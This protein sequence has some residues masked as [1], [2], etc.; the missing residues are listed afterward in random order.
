MPILSSEPTQFPAN[1][2]SDSTFADPQ[3]GRWWAMHTRSR[4]EKALA[5]HLFSRGVSYYLPLKQQTWRNNGRRFQSLLP[6]FPG[7]VFVRGSD[8]DRIAALESNLI[9][10]ILDVPD[11][12]RL[13]CDLRRVQCVLDADV[14]VGL[15]G[16]L[17]VGSSVKIV[18]G[19]LEGLSGVLIRHGSQL[20]LVIEVKFLRQ[21]ISVEVEPWMVEPA[22]QTERASA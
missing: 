7:Y 16:E 11:P 22:H 18:A 6:L 5:R 20:R 19:P 8:D 17:L 13:W 21:A 15:A 3:A 1:L 10:R 9:S 2:L 14:E 12:N 4:A